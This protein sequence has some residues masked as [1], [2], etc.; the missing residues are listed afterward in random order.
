MEALFS[1][2]SAAGELAMQLL[3]MFFGGFENLGRAMD[4]QLQS[5]ERRKNALLAAGK[6]GMPAIVVTSL[7]GCFVWYEV[8]RR[9]S[10]RT[11]EIA[12]QHAD[13]LDS[14]KNS[15]GTYRQVDPG[16]LDAWGNPL[17]VTWTKHALGETVIVASA[18][19][20]ER[21]GTEDDIV[22]S[23]LN[24]QS[25]TMAEVAAEVVVDMLKNARHDEDGR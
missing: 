22:T 25:T 7:V 23:R 5:T 11:Q 1:G 9:S 24:S 19:G 18:G 14:Q 10:I 12:N 3:C 2:I 16:K 8:S 17:R 20:D 13:W 6:L 21:P 4:S 15:D